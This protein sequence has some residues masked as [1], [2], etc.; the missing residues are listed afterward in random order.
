[1]FTS[2]TR[3]ELAEAGSDLDLGALQTLSGLN[4]LHLCDGKFSHLDQLA[5]LT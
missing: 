2:L 1:M 3:C 4:A 5:S